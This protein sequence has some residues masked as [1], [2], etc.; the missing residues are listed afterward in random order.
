MDQEIKQVEFREDCIRELFSEF[1]ECLSNIDDTIDCSNTEE[2]VSEMGQ[3]IDRIFSIGEEVYSR[4]VGEPITVPMNTFE[5]SA[6]VEA[7]HIRTGIPEE[8]I[9]ETFISCLEEREDKTVRKAWVETV[10]ELERERR[11][12]DILHGS[13]DV[14]WR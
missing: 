6:A 8:R 14:E 13:S 3:D 7:E 12:E 11:I 9:E 1:L 2:E 10:D 5:V 4:I